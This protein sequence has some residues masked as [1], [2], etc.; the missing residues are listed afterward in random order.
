MCSQTEAQIEAEDDKILDDMGYDKV[1][2]RGLGSFTNF[3]F[4]FTEVGV[5]VSIVTTWNYG[6]QYGGP[7]EIVWGF[8]VTF[9]MTMIVSLSMAEISSA[10]PSAGCVY[11]W[12]AQL[13]PENQAP[14]VS[15]ICGWFNF[16]GNC[17]GDAGFAASFAS[18]LIN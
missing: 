3:A 9:V 7:T 11:H 18:A 1:L 17:A 12:S 4:G 15:Y 6:L 2:Y 10:Y 5:L 16:I 8:F 13:V 14:L